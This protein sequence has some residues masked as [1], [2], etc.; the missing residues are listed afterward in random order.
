MWPQIGPCHWLCACLSIY[1]WQNGRI[2]G[3]FQSAGTAHDEIL[4]NRSHKKT[5]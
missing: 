3:E 4:Q 1:Y 5:K 2:G